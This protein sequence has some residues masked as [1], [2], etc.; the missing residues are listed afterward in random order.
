MFV[1]DP[2]KSMVRLQNNT[3]DNMLS[4]AYGVQEYQLVN[5]P[6]W[7]WPAM[8]T[9]MAKSDAEMD[10]KLA[11]LSTEDAQLEKQ[12]A[13]QALLADRF[14]LKVHWE[15]RE[16][17]VY[18]LVLAKG[19]PKIAAA[20]SMAPT[21]AEKQWMDSGDGG[22][23]KLL[24]LHQQNHGGGY[25]FIGHSC[26]M[27]MLVEELSSQFGRPV[28]DNTGLTSKYDFIVTTARQTAIGRRTIP[29]RHC[30]WIPRLKRSWDCSFNRPKARSRCW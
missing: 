22:E 24:P 12:H 16:G 18:N 29:T 21:Q 28:I 15:T 2:H 23:M 6:K 1:N 19:G 7:P 14:R 17:D 5:L 30:R 13:L 26:P 10:A 3:V 9:V 27:G 11:K 20:G 25:Q 4:V 8:F